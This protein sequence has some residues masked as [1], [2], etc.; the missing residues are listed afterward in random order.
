ML[1]PGS[2][3]SDFELSAFDA[4]DEFEST[5]SKTSDSDVTATDP[6]FSGIN[7][8]RPSDSGINLQSGV[9]LSQADSIELAPLSDDDLPT[10]KTAAAPA[11]KPAKPKPSL[12]ATPAPAVGEGEK[13]IFDDSDFE[14][15]L[16][17]I[18]EDS[19]DKTVQLDAGSDF[20]LD[21]S[22]TG[23][24]V[25]AIDEDVVDQNASTALAPSAF[26]EEEDEE[27]D[28]FES[29]VS[30][31]MSAAWSSSESSASP[32]RSSPAMVL[33][34]PDSD[35]EWGG[36]WVGL[37]SVTTLF[38]FFASFVAYDLVR[39]LYDFQSGGTMGSGLVRAIAG[40]FGGA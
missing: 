16:P 36:L 14:V 17:S 40:M 39:N 33:A 31:E 8:S 18:D 30:S 1:E 3:G 15:D 23:S 20:D 6:K 37:L 25:F 11:A 4:S 5:P 2:G 27:D 34:R 9:G 13:D 35:V 28:G 29:A 10:T 12:T 26:A 24:E 19:D 22:D 21:E 7:L 38:L 32:E